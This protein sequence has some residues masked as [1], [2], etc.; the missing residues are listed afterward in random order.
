[1]PTAIDKTITLGGDI[2]L[3]RMGFGAMRICGK[4]AWG[5]P[6]DRRRVAKV[7]ARAQ[8]LGIQFIDTANAYGPEISEYLLEENLHPYEGMCIAS[9]GGLE[10]SGPRTWIPNGRPEHLKIACINTLRRLRLERIDLY[11]LHANDDNVPLEES[12]G[13]LAQLQ[14]EGK[15]RHIGVSNFNVDQLKRAQSIATIV[16]VQNRYNLGYREH[17]AVLSYCEQ[18]GL[19]FIPW[20]PLATGDLT[21]DERLQSIAT[22][23]K[24]KVGQIALAWLLHKS[25]AMLPIP[26]TSS[27]KHLEQNHHSLTV[28]LTDDEMQ[29]LDAMAEG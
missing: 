19:A 21:R 4:G 24:A 28:K 22:A 15:I 10:R 14:Q 6:R 12:L 18:E 20:Y 13:A 11:Q 7:L 26:G 27:V 9:K 2:P 3:S 29:T 5:W 8:S 16:S 17:D 25:P 23:H 1:M